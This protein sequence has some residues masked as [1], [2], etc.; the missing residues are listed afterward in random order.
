MVAVLGDM[1]G[2]GF[3]PI[4]AELDRQLVRAEAEKEY[5][6]MDPE[7]ADALKAE[8]AEKQQTQLVEDANAELAK[9]MEARNPK[10]A[11]PEPESEEEPPPTE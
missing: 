6:G 2:V 10:K 3:M 11:A 7:V 8:T 5:E 4:E 9:V 1:G